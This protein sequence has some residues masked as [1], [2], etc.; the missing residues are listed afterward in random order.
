MLI[1]YPSTLSNWNLS[2]MTG[3]CDHTVHNLILEDVSLLE[4][5]AHLKA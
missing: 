4:M 2:M 1:P 3:G 5:C